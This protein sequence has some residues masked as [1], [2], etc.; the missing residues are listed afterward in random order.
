MSAHPSRPPPPRLRVRRAAVLGS[1]L[2]VVVVPGWR[3]DLWPVDH[4][5][6]LAASRAADPDHVFGIALDGAEPGERW[7]AHYTDSRLASWLHGAGMAGA[8]TSVVT[9]D[10]AA[11]LPPGAERADGYFRVE[12][13]VHWP[14][15]RPGGGVHWVVPAPR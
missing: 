5:A 7:H 6:V 8:I 12:S 11:H 4:D 15:W 13:T 10:H 2:A 14:W 9:P 1:L 3:A